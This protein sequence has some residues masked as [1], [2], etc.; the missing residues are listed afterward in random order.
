MGGLRTRAGP[1]YGPDILCF[2]PTNYYNTLKEKHEPRLLFE[3]KFMGF[4]SRL[5]FF[6]KLNFFSRSS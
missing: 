4:F 1:A 5:L 3:K 6:D 2:S